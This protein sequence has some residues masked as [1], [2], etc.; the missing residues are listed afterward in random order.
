MHGPK[1]KKLT[2]AVDQSLIIIRT[3]EHEY[4]SLP[5]RNPVA[6]RRRQRPAGGPLLTL[7]VN[8]LLWHF[9]VP[10]V[11][12]LVVRDVALRLGDRDDHAVPLLSVDLL[13]RDGSLEVVLLE[14][15][16]EGSVK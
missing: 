13:C 10:G 9:E 12:Q 11:E 4:R 15:K 3:T 1:K 7:Y 6:Q 8:K 5:T 16:T 14:G 2:S